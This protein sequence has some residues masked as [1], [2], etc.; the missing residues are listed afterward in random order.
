MSIGDDGALTVSNFT[1][2]YGV[3]KNLVYDEIAAGRLRAVKVGTRKTL[4]PRQ[5]ARQWLQSLEPVVLARS[6]TESV[7][8]SKSPQT[9]TAAHPD[10]RW[11]P[12]S[13]ERSI[14]MRPNSKNSQLC[15]LKTVPCAQSPVIVSEFAL[16]P[17]EAIRGAQAR[18]LKDSLHCTDN[19][20][21]ELARL[22]YG[23]A[24]Q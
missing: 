5:S 6:E 19:T 24:R 21:R 15:H 13:A 10:Q 20:A 1:K 11:R 22:I 18:R 3:G 4:I 8:A 23:E 9:K 14:N 7:P 12:L 16:S 17:W 2:E